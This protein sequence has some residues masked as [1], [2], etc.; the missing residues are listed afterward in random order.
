MPFVNIRITKE[1]GEPTSK[2][3]QELIAGVT[4]LL[5]KVLNKNKASTVVII[6]EIDT[7]NYGLDGKSIT[8]VEKKK[9]S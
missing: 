8:Q 7:D 9:A 1:N 5:A 4:D 6:D 3:K 2:Q